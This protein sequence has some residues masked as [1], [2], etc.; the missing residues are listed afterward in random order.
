MPVIGSAVGGKS[1]V[2]DLAAERRHLHDCRATKGTHPG[3]HG[4]SER[5]G[6]GDVQR[7]RLDPIGVGGAL[8][9][10][11]TTGEFDNM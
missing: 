8:T 5:G 1:G 7:R 2:G 4:A 6:V 11:L 9:S 10:F 3:Q